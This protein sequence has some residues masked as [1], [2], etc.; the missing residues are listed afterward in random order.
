V[1]LPA[2]FIP[3]SLDTSGLEPEVADRLRASW[4]AWWEP[5]GNELRAAPPTEGSPEERQAVARLA[6]HIFGMM[7][8]FGAAFSTA[9]QSGVERTIEQILLR[10]A[11][12]VETERRLGFHWLQ[13]ALEML[14]RIVARLVH[15]APPEAIM[16]AMAHLSAEEIEERL[17]PLSMVV[18]R[19][20]LSAFVA[21]DLI[22]QSTPGEFCFWAR[23]AAAASR[24]VDVWMP[25]LYWT[26]GTT[27]DD[28]ADLH[29]DVAL[30]GKGV[31]TVLRLLD[32]A[33]GPN[34]AMLRLFR[35]DDPQAHQG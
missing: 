18:L 19:L 29:A 11:E 28:E 2:L 8:E 34:A 10:A 27:Q 23:R 5:L 9:L 15:A 20:E 31:A 13:A 33:P 6:G 30:D 12:D 1:A 35:G 26:F 3:S 4:G 21:L 16:A 25:F 17:D 7:G 24:A 32:E 22:S 14:G